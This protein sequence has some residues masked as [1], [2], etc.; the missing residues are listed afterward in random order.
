M[1]DS[2]CPFGPA[3]R[4]EREQRKISQWTVSVR[5]QYHTRNIQRIEGGLRQPG[6]LLALR[7]VA[8]VDAD[9]GKFFE[10]L[11][12]KI[13]SERYDGLLSPTKRVRVTYQP[14]EATEGLKSLFG[15]LLVQAR[16]AVGM[17]LEICS[18]LAGQG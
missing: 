15:P 5:L 18:L 6:V 3:F 1:Q 2:L 12:Q 14:P 4:R 10:T 8:A 17:Q 11:C 9:P 13:A 16:Q 7:M